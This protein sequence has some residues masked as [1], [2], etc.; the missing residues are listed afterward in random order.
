MANAIAKNYGD[1]GAIII[2]AGDNDIRIGT[3][4]LSFE[5]VREALCT[6]IYYSFCVENRESVN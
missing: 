4:G 2:T 1:R 5:E 3:E 6:A